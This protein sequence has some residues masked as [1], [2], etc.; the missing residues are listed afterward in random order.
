MTKAAVQKGPE[1]EPAQP[2]EDAATGVL[3]EREPEPE[4]ELRCTIRGLRACW[5][6]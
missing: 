1:P 3:A 4:A 6:K 5:T 2:A